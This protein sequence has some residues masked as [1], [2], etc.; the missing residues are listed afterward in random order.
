MAKN[1][2]NM[3]VRIVFQNFLQNGH[4]RS[5][6]PFYFIIYISFGNI[7]KQFIVDDNRAKI[8]FIYFIV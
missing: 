3:G 6:I 1:K 7:K 2:N 5:H 8:E 4:W